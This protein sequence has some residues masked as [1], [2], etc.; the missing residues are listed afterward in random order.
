VSGV[1]PLT[2]LGTN[3]D[4]T[5]ENFVS[6]LQISSFYLFCLSF[7]LNNCLYVGVCLVEDLLI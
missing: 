5:L 3:L 4:C 7:W 1:T 6:H 2:Y